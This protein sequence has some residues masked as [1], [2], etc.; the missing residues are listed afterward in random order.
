[1][2]VNLKGRSF[3]TLMDFSPDEIDYLLTLAADLKSKKRAG[4]RGS[5]L[6]GKNVALIFEK[7]ST[8]TRCAFTV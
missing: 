1:M 3:L 5:T 6:A 2:P 7:S 8:R 4:I